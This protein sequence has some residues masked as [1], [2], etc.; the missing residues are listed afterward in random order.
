[1]QPHPPPGSRTQA[2]RRLSAARATS[3]A[4]GGCACGADVRRAVEATGGYLEPES[5]AWHVRGHTVPDGWDPE[6]Y[7]VQFKQDHHGAQD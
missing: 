4:D 5:G 6:G 1:M 7:I 3:C 2:S